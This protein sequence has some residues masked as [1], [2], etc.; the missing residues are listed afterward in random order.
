MTFG[1]ELKAWR[2]SARLTQEQAAS[3]LDVPVR[4][5]QEW[6]QDR[7]TPNQIG[8]IRKLIAAYK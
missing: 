6:E 2:S 8:P 7:S 5:L 4:S 3:Y 1:E